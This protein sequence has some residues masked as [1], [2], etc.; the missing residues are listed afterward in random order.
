ML[1]KSCDINT[2]YWSTFYGQ[3]QS[4][5]DVIVTSTQYPLKRHF[6]LELSYCAFTITYS[7][8]QLKWLTPIAIVS[9][10]TIH[11]TFLFHYF[12]WWARKE[13]GM[14]RPL[15]IYFLKVF[16]M[17]KSIFSSYH[18]ISEFRKFHFWNFQMSAVSLWRHETYDTVSTLVISIKLFDKDCFEN[19][20]FLLL[21][22][23]TKIERLKLLLYIFTHEIVSISSL[24]YVFLTLSAICLLGFIKTV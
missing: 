10:E 13:I 2:V 17:H 24:F 19:N 6:V 9:S 18:S 11:K 1:F 22:H 21:Y 3:H 15:L 5:F 23:A 16:L 7:L 20:I 8:Q 4:V 12:P 14:S